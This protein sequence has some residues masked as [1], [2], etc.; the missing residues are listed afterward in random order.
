MID[1]IIDN[2]GELKSFHLA[3]QINKFVIFMISYYRLGTNENKYFTTDAVR[4]VRNKSTFDI[5]G[6][7]QDEVLKGYSRTFFKKWDEYHLKD[8][9]EELYIDLMKDIDKLKSL[10]NFME[11]NIDNYDFGFYE[12]KKLSMLKEKFKKRYINLSVKDING[13]HNY[14]IDT[15]LI[16]DTEIMEILSDLNSLVC[17][18]R[19]QQSE[20]PRKNSEIFNLKNINEYKKILENI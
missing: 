20:T 5:G 13:I 12:L 6:Q 14:S 11:N 19:L 9:T 15:Y 18:S 17:V 8:L 3:L 16:S 10:Y 7:C 2:K 4:F 1:S